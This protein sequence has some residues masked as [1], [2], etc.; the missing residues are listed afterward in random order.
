MKKDVLK[1]I[2][3]INKTI[4][5]IGGQSILAEQDFRKIA[6][7]FTDLGFELGQLS[8]KTL[9]KSFSSN[10]LMKILKEEGV[11]TS[12]KAWEKKLNQYVSGKMNDRASR[13]LMVIL[14]ESVPEMRPILTTELK[15][16]VKTLG[17]SVGKNS[18]DMLVSALNNPTLSRKFNDEWLDM[19]G[20]RPPINSMKELVKLQGLQG[21]LVVLFQEVKSF[22]K[23]RKTKSNDVMDQLDNAVVEGLSEMNLYGKTY[24][25]IQ[26]LFK[27]K[28]GKIFDMADVKMNYNSLDDLVE[29]LAEATSKGESLNKYL[30]DD[31]YI[32]L[33]SQ[34]DL[35]KSMMTYLRNNNLLKREFRAGR[36]SDDAIND[37]LGGKA[38]K[39]ELEDLISAWKKKP[40][41]VIGPAWK[42]LSDTVLKNP[43]FWKWYAMSQI[44]SIIGSSII[45]MI[46][47]IK[48]TDKAMAGT[49][50][51]FYAQIRGAKDIV[52]TE[53]QLSDEEA[54][55]LATRLHSMI[56]YFSHN[57]E[58]IKAWVKEHEDKIADA[59]SIEEFDELVKNTGGVY[60]GNLRY[61]LGVDDDSIS[62]FYK[63]PPE[64][65]VPTILAA[66]QICY[67]YE[68][69]TGKKNSL[70]RAFKSMQAYLT[71]IPILQ[72]LL[73]DGEEQITSQLDL[74]PWGVS[75]DK[76]TQKVA[77]VINSFYDSWPKF[78]PYLLDENEEK[79]YSQHEGRIPIDHLALLSEQLGY[80]GGSEKGQQHW[81]DNLSSEDFNIAYCHEKTKCPTIYQYSKEQFL[82]FKRNGQMKV[83]MDEDAFKAA[84]Q[85]VLD[86]LLDEEQS[87]W[88]ATFWGGYQ[89]G[90]EG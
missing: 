2:R 29:E 54:E 73:D 19:F 64:G 76:T 3:K 51:D 48:Y 45:Q 68:E 87:S 49:H 26:T 21:K 69:I 55:V 5:S 63:D 12:K 38:T 53:G 72:H 41:P 8:L 74:K 67:F 46:R 56:N 66:S 60:L 36:L 50:Q 9:P 78:P 37:L 86:K 89:E 40:I 79:L 13:K 71:V 61:L 34:P 82:E 35:N 14:G 32:L 81:L 90:A 10:K 47:A 22:F 39:L 58:D 6:T 59:D 31:L 84:T 75:V 18:D 83:V 52:L 70:W 11:A 7:V 88:I 43:K 17:S 28:F 77:T 42:G 24:A 27:E 30:R 25:E 1:E 44:G 20:T 16:F 65:E 62:S 4:M 80:V 23:F 33:R 85:A 57:E 15:A